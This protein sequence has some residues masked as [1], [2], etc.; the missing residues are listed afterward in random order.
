MASFLSILAERDREVGNSAIHAHSSTAFSR[1]PPERGMKCPHRQW[2]ANSWW[3][4]VRSRAIRSAAFLRIVLRRLID[5]VRTARGQSASPSK[6]GCG[7][8]RSW[9]RST[10]AI[11]STLLRPSE[12]K[13][14]AQ[15][16]LS[17]LARSAGPIIFVSSSTYTANRDAPSAITSRFISTPSVDESQ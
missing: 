1:G 17:G 8:G 7:A 5:A 13:S 6:I 16:R 14:P 11:G 4:Q 15:Q 3:A 12:A 2:Q 9:N 10:A